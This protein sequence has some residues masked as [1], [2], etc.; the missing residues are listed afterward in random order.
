MGQLSTR[1]AFCCVAHV[2]PTRREGLCGYRPRIKHNLCVHCRASGAAR[3][4][5]LPDAR[6]II[7]TTLTNSHP[8]LLHHVVLEAIHLR[9]QTPCASRTGC[10]FLPTSLPSNRLDMLN[11]FPGQTAAAGLSVQPV[12][13]SSA[14]MRREPNASN[15]CHLA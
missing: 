8:A 1:S 5:R 13:P 11:H 7:V 2:R 3:E 12:Q 4:E 15:A 9:S 14:N 6:S 10:H